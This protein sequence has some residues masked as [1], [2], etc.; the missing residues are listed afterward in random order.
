ML[1]PYITEIVT[2]QHIQTRKAPK[3]EVVYVQPRSEEIAYKL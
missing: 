1:Y 2:M 3:R